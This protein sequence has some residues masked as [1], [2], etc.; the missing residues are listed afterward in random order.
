MVQTIGEGGDM[1]MIEGLYYLH[2]LGSSTNMPLPDAQV[3]P[4]SSGVEH[5]TTGLE[6]TGGVP[7]PVPNA[8]V[9]PT[10]SAMDIWI[11]DWEWKHIHVLLQLGFET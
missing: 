1:N 9:V 2:A 4:I 10:L 7:T 8:T 11:E 3:S 5:P 6:G